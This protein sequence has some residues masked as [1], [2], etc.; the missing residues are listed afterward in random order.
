[1][2][3]GPFFCNGRNNDAAFL[4]DI[5]TNEGNITSND[6]EQIILIVD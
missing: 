6:L 5:K 1:M 2:L 4:S 3:V